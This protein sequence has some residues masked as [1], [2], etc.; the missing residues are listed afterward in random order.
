MGIKGRRG[1]GHGRTQELRLTKTLVRRYIL[2]VWDLWS[3]GEQRVEKER[4]ISIYSHEQKKRGS[5]EKRAKESNYFRLSCR[6]RSQTRAVRHNGSINALNAWH[7][8]G[9]Y[10]K[11]SA[12][13]RQIDNFDN[14]H[15]LWKVLL[16]SSRDERRRLLFLTRSQD[17]HHMKLTSVWR[18]LVTAAR[19]ACW[20]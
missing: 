7:S 9:H 1:S 19:A 5:T 10:Q 14:E 15:N 3:C 17:H 4:G 11:L 20:Y 12:Q 6:D 2:C 8:A 18:A 13:Y 16:G